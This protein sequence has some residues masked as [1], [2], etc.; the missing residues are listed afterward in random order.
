[1]NLQEWKEKQK[2]HQIK[3]AR[4]ADILDALDS[5]NA[6]H[7][8]DSITDEMLE[9]GQH[10]KMIALDLV[11]REKL[12]EL[13]KISRQNVLDFEREWHRVYGGL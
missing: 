12:E 13:A 4:R 6:A 9:S 7:L 11:R 3:L 2:Q 1:M 10:A 8:Q 5:M